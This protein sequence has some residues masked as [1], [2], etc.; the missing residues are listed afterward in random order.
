MTQKPLKKP[1]L[2]FSLALL[3]AASVLLVVPAHGIYSFYSQKKQIEADMHRKA[4]ESLASLAENAAPFIEAYAVREYQKLVQTEIALR[5]YAAILVEDANMAGVLSQ[6][7]YVSGMVRTAEGHYIAYDPSDPAHEELLSSSYINEHRELLHADG[8]HLGNLSIYMTDAEVRAKQQQVFADSLQNSLLLAI[9]LMGMLILFSRRRILLPL[10]RLSAALEHRDAD[11]IPVATLPVFRYRELSAL[12]DTMNNMLDMIRRSRT[13]LVKERSRLSDVIEGTHVGT[14]EWNVQTGEVQF[15]EYWAE[16]LGYR[17]EEL[18][19]ISIE[20]WMQLAHPD[21]LEESDRQLKRHFASEVPYY[22]CEARMRHKAGHWVWV[23]DRGK[24][25]RRTD[26][27]QPLMMYGTHQDITEQ[28][29]NELRLR[30]AASV[31]EHVNDGI[32][33]T[34][35]KGL[36]QDVNQAFVRL[37]GYTEQEVVGKNASLLKSGCHDQVFYEAMWQALLNKGYW[38]GEIWNRRKN[39]EIYPELLRI[40]RIQGVG[41][42]DINYVA[43]MT[44]ISHQKAYQRQLEQLAHFD[45]LTGL[46]NRV[47]LADRLHNAMAQ[48]SRRG[49]L[50]A[51]A[52]L[53]LDGFKA[54]NDQ[55]GHDTGDQLLVTMAERMGQTLRES[56]TLVRLGGDE[57]VVLLPALTESEDCLPVIRRLLSAVSEPCEISGH[58]VQV[59]ASVGVAFYPQNGGVDAEQLLRQAD[60]AMYKA[61]L[62]GKNRYHVSDEAPGPLQNRA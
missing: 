22:R 7:H 55:H 40:S 5:D 23:L 18:Y 53:D 41:G 54:V 56:D 29:E 27:G 46:P 1:S 50:L 39:G 48:A 42:V 45:A 36:I 35:T 15:D 8:V 60:Q 11:G 19:P 28:K 6:P 44:D 10:S 25:T 62:A 12:T 34:D 59:S 16:I 37:T 4:Q 61:K 20:T 43:L 14:W 51:V 9:I 21:D 58:R 49:E 26:D 32:M 47:I 52:F 31:F 33:I 13:E 38:S 3:A 17:L 30:L 2:L 24:V 57:F